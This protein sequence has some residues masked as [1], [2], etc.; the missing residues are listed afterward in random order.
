[1]RR[2]SIGDACYHSLFVSSPTCILLLR[3]SS[4]ELLDGSGLVKSFKCC[5]KFFLRFRVICKVGDELEIPQQKE[6]Y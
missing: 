6:M 4:S 5:C 2:N 1:M 3:R